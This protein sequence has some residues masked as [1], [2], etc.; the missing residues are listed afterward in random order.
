[1]SGDP[2]PARV[3]GRGGD[4][5]RPPSR[6][7]RDGA[8]AGFQPRD[9]VGG[10]ETG[11]DDPRPPPAS[12]DKQ[13]GVGGCAGRGARGFAVSRGWDHRRRPDRRVRRH[14]SGREALRVSAARQVCDASKHIERRYRHGRA[15]D[16]RRRFD[17]GGA[18]RPRQLRS[19]RRRGQRRRAGV[20][21]HRLARLRRVFHQIVGNVSVHRGYDGRRL[22]R[23]RESRGRQD[24]FRQLGMVVQVLRAGSARD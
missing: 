3:A 5:R 6:A 9:A 14:R 19:V 8:L 22:L 4:R 7:R 16:A 1:M 23:T 18:H 24:T 13:G 10:A 12:V 17:R 2:T 15:R 11:G 20:H 21:G